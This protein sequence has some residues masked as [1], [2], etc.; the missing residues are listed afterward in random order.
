MANISRQELFHF[1]ADF[2]GAEVRNRRKRRENTIKIIRGKEVPEK[3]I[4]IYPVRE[5]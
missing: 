2:H 5:K 1:L 4:E 3:T